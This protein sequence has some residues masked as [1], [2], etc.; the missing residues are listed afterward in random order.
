MKIKHTI[1]SLK[2]SLFIFFSFFFLS[3]LL[4][5]NDKTSIKGKI[6]DATD[7]LPINGVIITIDENKY[8]QSSQNGEFE[9]YE[10]IMLPVKIKFSMQGYTDT[11]IQ[12][13]DTIQLANKL[14]IYLKPN[15]KNIEDI[16]ITATRT[17]KKIKEVPV[18]THVLYTKDFVKYG[19]VSTTELLQREISGFDFA[20]FSYQTKATFQGMNGKYLLFLIDGERIAGEMDGNIDYSRINLSQI[21]RIEIIKGASSVL[22]GSNAIGGIINF[23]YKKPKYNFENDAYLKYSANNQ[24]EADIGVSKKIKKFSFQSSLAYYS[25]N[26]YD[27]TP[28]DILSTTQYK[29]FHYNTRQYL[30]YQANPST[31]FSANINA[32]YK[33]I[34]DGNPDFSPSDHGYLAYSG[35]LKI[36]KTFNNDFNVELSHLYD[37]Y[38]NYDILFL[39]NDQ[40]R[41][42]AFDK[43]NNTRILLSKKY[44]KNQFVCGTDYILENLFS[45]RITNEYAN[46]NDIASY[47]QDEHYLSNK[48]SLTI[49]IRYTYNKT[50]KHNIV[51]KISLMYTNK[52][53]I[54]IRAAYGKGYR[55]PSLKDLYF[56]FNHAGMFQLIGNPN[57]RPEKSDYFDISLEYNKKGFNFSINN[58]LHLLTDM[59]N[60]KWISKDTNQYI[61]IEKARIIGADFLV[62]Y[63]FKRVN[64]STSL[65]LTD[66]YNTTSKQKI[67]NIASAS[68][69]GSISIFY[70]LLKKQNIIRLS[71]KYTSKRKYEPVN[72]NY[73]I[74]PAYILLYAS[75][76]ISINYKWTMSVGV[77]NILNNVMPKSFSNLSPGRTYYFSI[78]WNVNK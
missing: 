47:I 36:N 70:N 49:G 5:I 24:I 25:T 57:L 77:D 27:L 59:I 40:F 44:G 45:T 9:I 55:S 38:E 56:N 28:E 58:Y 42:T 34:F 35:N 32:Y 10:K 63:S 12:L 1:K 11:I 51:P 37:L 33:R 18:L 46:T 60:G 52:N 68:G 6:M 22:Y 71:A 20:N 31:S 7:S 73:Y 17:P 16:V 14:S 64:I 53:Y 2:I 23:I 72:D 66:A 15:I 13:M 78:K 67:Y 30:S 41:K 8:Y 61:N 62:S 4:S 19:M 50:Y 65:S 3:P 39:K 54:I 21:E 69:N 43:Y 48:I 76:G 29:M 75:Y 26:G 74:D